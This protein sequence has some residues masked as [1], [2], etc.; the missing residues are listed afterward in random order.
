[1]GP[2]AYKPGVFW[3]DKGRGVIWGLSRLKGDGLKQRALRGSLLTFIG[4]GGAQVLRLA[5]NLVLT[6]L[7]APEIFGLMAL[8]QMVLSAA[9]MLSVLGINISIM[10]N[11]RGK[12]PR[13]L[14]TAWTLQIIRGAVLWA[15]IALSAPAIAAFYGYPELTALLSVVGV[16]AF[17]SGFQSTKLATSNRDLQLGRLTVVELASQVLGIL[18]MIGLAWWL[19]SVWALALGSMGA[20]AAKVVLSHRLLAGEPNRLAWDSTALWAILNMGKY[21]LFSSALGFVINNGDRAILGKFV[22]LTDLG[23]Y[24]IG[25]FL[26]TVP[27]MMA[28][29]FGPRVMLPIYREAPPHEGAANRQKLRKVRGGLTLILL[30]GGLTIAFCG[31]WLVGLLYEDRYAGAG[32]VLILLC[33]T[34]MPSIILM[35]YANLYLAQGNARD[36]TVLTAL[37]ALVQT[38]ALYLGVREWGVLGAVL[39]PLSVVV[40]YPLTAWYAHRYRGWDPA[41]DAALTAVAVLGAAAALWWHEDLIAGMLSGG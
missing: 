27:L 37:T 36:F 9:E 3:P 1:M 10:Q 34:A 5:S 12:E 39:A 29:Q 17:V 2:G 25:F 23:I 33:L 30:L 21:I 18:L 15:A 11:P 19:R 41:L 6:R 26:A 16:S 7:L 20:A 13:F 35:P 38:V 8:V 28:R 4:F 32:P 40:T 22:S 31:Q 24:N 14:N